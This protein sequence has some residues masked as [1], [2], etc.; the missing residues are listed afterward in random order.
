MVE[1]P[2]EDLKEKQLEDAKKKKKSTGVIEKYKQKILESYE[3]YSKERNKIK[4]GEKYT[5]EFI[6]DFWNFFNKKR[7]YWSLENLEK[8]EFMKIFDS[9]RSEWF[10]IG[11]LTLD[12][13]SG[14]MAEKFSQWTTERKAIEGGLQNLKKFCDD[15]S[16]QMPDGVF[17][18]FADSVSGKFDPNN[19][20]ISQSSGIQTVEDISKNWHMF[21]DSNKI[22]LWDNQK[23][24]TDKIVKNASYNFDHTEKLMIVTSIKKVRDNLPDNANLRVDFDSIFSLPLKATWNIKKLSDLRV[25][26]E[27][28][29]LNNSSVFSKDKDFK[30]LKSLIVGFDDVKEEFNSLGLHQNYD[31]SLSFQKFKNTFS[32]LIS[33]ELIG[34][35]QEAKEFVDDNMDNLFKLFNDFPPYA[36]FFEIFPYNWKKIEKDFPEL[37]KQSKK[38]DDMLKKSRS[39]ETSDEDKW[40]LMKQ[41]IDERKKFEKLKREWY[42][43]ALKKE[44]SS[45]A[46]VLKDLVW[47]NFDF[48]WLSKLKK[49]TIIDALKKKKLKELIENEVPNLLNIDSKDYQSL[50]D[51]FFDMDKD[52]LLIPCGSHW[53]YKLK[54]KKDF[55]GGPMKE[56]PSISYMKDTKQFPFTIEVD[57]NN[58]S[59]S[60]EFFEETDIWSSSYFFFNAQNSS[61]ENWFKI[62]ESYKVELKRDD[63]T[64]FE[65]YLS[66]FSI[67]DKD[68]KAQSLYLYSDP[69]PLPSVGRKIAVDKKSILKIDAKDQSGYELKVLD[70]KLNLTWDEVNQLLLSSTLWEAQIE[71]VELD[72]EKIKI[73]EKWL[74]DLDTYKDTW[75]NNMKREDSTKDGPWEGSSA[76]SEKDENY[77]NFLDSFN[78]LPWVSNIEFEDWAYFY[79][80]LWESELPPAGSWDHYAKMRISNIDKSAG[81]FDIQINGWELKLSKD[82]EW[83]THTLKLHPSTFD[84]FHKPDAFGAWNVFKF[85]PLDKLKFQDQVD[86]LDNSDFDLS[87]LSTFQ[88]DIWFDWKD[89]YFHDWDINKNKK[90]K[91][92]YFW[93]TQNFYENVTEKDGKEVTKSRK[94]QILFEVNHN[95]NGTFD[96]K[97]KIIDEKS[98]WKKMMRYHQIMNYTDFLLFIWQK[99]LEPL[100]DDLWDKKKNDVEL[101]WKTIKPKRTTMSLGNLL[102][103]IKMWKEK[104]VDKWKEKNKEKTEDLYNYV[105]WE[106]WLTKGGLY[107]MLSKLPGHA[108][109]VFWSLHAGWMLERDNLVWNKI[110]KYTDLFEQDVNPGY[111]YYTHFHQILL[112]WVPTNDPYF[113]A[114]MLFYWKWRWVRALFWE[115]HQRRF[116]DFQAKQEAEVSRLQSKWD[117]VAAELAQN[118]L[119]KI[120]TQYIVDVLTLGKMARNDEQLQV[121][122]YS[123]Q[124]ASELQTRSND[125][126]TA[127]KVEEKTDQFEAENLSFDYANVEYEKAIDATRPYKALPYLRRMVACA[128]WDAQWN[129][130][131]MHLSAFMLSGLMLHG[132]DIQT[133]KIFQK[134]SRTHWFL[135]WLWTRDLKQQEKMARLFNYISRDSWSKQFSKATWFD[136]TK[137]TLWNAGNM[138]SFIKDFNKRRLW[139]WQWKK[140]IDFLSLKGFSKEWVETFVGY[141]D[142]I[143]S[144]DKSILEELNNARL[145]WTSE[146][147]DEKV[148]A[149]YD[150]YSRRPLALGKSVMQDFMQMQNGEFKWEKHI[151]EASESLWNSVA[152]DIPRRN[153]W[154]KKNEVRYVMQAFFSWFDNIFN[155]GKRSQFIRWF[156]KAKQIAEQAEEFN[157]NGATSMW[158]KKMNEARE[159][160]RYLINGE[161][162]VDRRGVPTQFWAALDAFREFF[163]ENLLNIDSED[164][165]ATA[166]KEFVVDFHTPYEYLDKEKYGILQQKWGGWLTNELAKK[167]HLYQD[168]TKYLNPTLYK[169]NKKLMDMWE[170]LPSFVTPTKNKTD[171]FDGGWVEDI[172]LKANK[173]W[174][175]VTG[176]FEAKEKAPTDN[177]WQSGAYSDEDEND[178]IADRIR[179]MY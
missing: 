105:V 169:L 6:E 126:F 67:H 104:I 89:F 58:D 59:D 86:L 40:W 16:N 80:K 49:Q 138:K 121:R 74:W 94:E 75:E 84:N 110:K 124:F 125:F 46:E 47:S 100:T 7:L 179:S 83:T 155:A 149:N 57:L 93:Y 135:P 158:I 115:A 43:D 92:K 37:A 176:W 171:T 97:S 60:Q 35:M 33:N 140:I 103:M 82:W 177:G 53:F 71:N 96:V 18:K 15:K 172:D 70:R 160:L 144:W 78:N 134:L 12:D 127:K 24:Y 23:E 48:A 42:I 170:K 79:V 50:V 25:E 163:E 8:E 113:M 156:A 56:L 30:K 22:K 45:L 85:P 130:I 65:W 72:K 174:A 102:D 81:T 109:T 148:M 52:E 34:K 3:K 17:K 39:S 143:W 27:H 9:L 5:K 111:I 20:T 157:K 95:K 101:E 32:K 64:V 107:A 26:L 76:I 29:L 162:T 14:K 150:G 154:N 13:K 1:V 21:L 69:I 44:D 2:H 161:I 114:G 63:W 173:K 116:L 146:D 55:Y 90:G 147:L 178:D 164:I 145:E 38:I 108:S 106:H 36:D 123:K 62:N 122:R 91:V 66:P 131:F 41:L 166:W 88:K 28:F 120:E 61:N 133:K 87:G 112:S 98:W 175:A 159:I 139:W 10:S 77:K 132:V 99:N 11:Q 153:L 168:S 54:V 117:I 73:L 137:L 19:C 129:I 118:D 136:V 31:P 4:P 68:S 119:I 151:R 152:R 142:D 165:K 167:K 141:D 51:D 128:S